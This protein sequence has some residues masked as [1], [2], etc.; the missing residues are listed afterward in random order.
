MA[1]TANQDREDQGAEILQSHDS[2]YASYESET[3]ICKISPPP[4]SLCEGILAICGCN[5]AICCPPS[6]CCLCYKGMMDDQRFC[7]LMCRE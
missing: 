6:V 3:S 4:T 5:T 7:C 1:G 2:N